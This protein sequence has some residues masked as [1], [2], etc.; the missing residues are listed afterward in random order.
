[1]QSTT[2]HTSTD[3][4]KAEQLRNLLREST[5][6][7]ITGLLEE[8]REQGDFY[9]VEPL[10]ELLFSTR[11]EPLKRRVVGLLADLSDQRAADV[12]ARCI[13]RHRNAPELAA[14]VSVCWQSRLDFTSH[15]NLF[16]DLLRNAPMATGIEAYS[17]LDGMLPALPAEQRNQCL[18]TLRQGIAS[19]EAMDS[20]GLIAAL[21]TSAE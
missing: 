3:E 14:L 16:V 9:A 2:E 13:K 4:R 19:D 17:V 6:E 18:A 11:S 15:A 5:D 1:M 20:A 10:V 7:S 12:I 21:L 8:L